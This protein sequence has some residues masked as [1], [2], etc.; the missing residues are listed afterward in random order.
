[1]TIILPTGDVVDTAGGWLQFGTGTPPAVT[2][3]TSVVYTPA[4]TYEW[5]TFRLKVLAA[6]AAL[7]AALNLK[8]A[9]PPTLGS[10][11]G[12]LAHAGGNT[13]TLTGTGFAPGCVGGLELT[14]YLATVPLTYAGP[15]SLTFVM[16]ATGG[17]TGATTITIINPDGGVATIAATVT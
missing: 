10:V 2:L 11:A 12:T 6:L 1:M 9:N 7:A 14:G 4:S 15:T 16:P 17:L 3:N 8:S 5:Y 13:I